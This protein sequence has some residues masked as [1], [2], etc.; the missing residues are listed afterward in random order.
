MKKWRNKNAKIKEVQMMNKR[1]MKK[2]IQTVIKNMMDKVM[3]NV[4]I[5]DPFIPEKH[6]A[7][8][9]LYAALVPDD[10]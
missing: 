3:D 6:H 9:P 2:S 7:E 8:K 4:L 5:K 10:F 1:E